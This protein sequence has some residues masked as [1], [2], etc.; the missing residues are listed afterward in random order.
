MQKKNQQE[1]V[2]SG[3]EALKLSG[4]LD[5][6]SSFIRPVSDGA[7]VN[8]EVAAM[9]LKDFFRK[10]G[11]RRFLRGVEIVCAVSCGL[12]IAERESIEAAINK[13]GFNDVILAESV[14]GLLPFINPKG[15]AVAVIGG[16]TTE[17]G[18]I[19]EDGIITACSL[20]LGG[21]AIDAKIA[22]R[23]LDS[24]NLK[25]SLNTS[26]ELKKNLGSLYENDTSVMSVTGRDILDGA[27]KREE[28]S[29]ESLRAPITTCFKTILEVTE[30]LLT[31]VP[32]AMI[33]D[34]T[35]RGLYIAGGS[36]KMQGLQDFVSRYLKIPVFIDPEPETAVVRGLYG[37]NFFIQNT[38]KKAKAR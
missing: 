29:A 16:G 9:M 24:Y 20:N 12:S 22:E 17:I 28:I 26:E 37:Q 33:S 32:P 38:P 36:A 5:R 10:A 6:D 15:Q 14:T 8:V 25:I 3:S 35:S 30:S 4:K 21:R 23:V 18:V 7:V 13:A 11:V 19:S 31:T 2:A 1:L 27:V 34:I